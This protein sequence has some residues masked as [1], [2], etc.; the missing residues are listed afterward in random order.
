MHAPQVLSQCPDLASENLPELTGKGT[1]GHGSLDM[2]TLN[3]A[4]NAHSQLMSPD[5]NTLL[6]TAVNLSHLV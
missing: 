1:Q 2:K 4:E 3:I 6:N 5:M